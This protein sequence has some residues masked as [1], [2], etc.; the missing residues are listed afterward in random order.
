MATAAA[1][2]GA[3]V[4]VGSAVQ[5]RNAR[6]DAAEGQQSANIQSAQLLASAGRGAEQDISIAG[7][8]AQQSIQEGALASSQ[9][10]QPFAAPGQQAFRSAQSQLLSNRDVGGPLA[11]SIR[12]SSLS[13]ADPNIFDL[14]GPV[15][16][17]VRRQADL[18]VSGATPAFNQAQLTAGLQGLAAT[19]DIASIN[20]RALNLQ[21]QIA[22]S[23]AAGR[24]SA[25][26]GANPQ[27]AQLA[28]G[29]NEGRLLSDVAG[30][31]GNVSI[32]NQLAQLA[33]RA[34]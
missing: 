32:A 17:E 20:Q 27:L 9:E 3:V 11:Q 19:G 10:L 25:L 26:V 18:S 21:S 24:A 2:I 33:G 4:S 12:N 5:Q 8:R 34:S 6:Q 13:A 1:V 15:G 7:D 30:Q 23:S 22:G 28:I 14:S 29:A 31:Q 16:E